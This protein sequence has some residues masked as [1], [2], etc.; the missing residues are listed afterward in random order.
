MVGGSGDVEVLGH[1]ASVQHGGIGRFTADP[2][3]GRWA[4]SGPLY[5]MFGST[6]D[7]VTPDWEFV[8]NHVPETGRAMV[9]EA[10][11]LACD[12][13]GPFTWSH[14][15]VDDAGRVHSVMV[16]G[17]T[18][19]VP[20]EGSDTKEGGDGVCRCLRGYV[21]DL[22]GL[23]VGAA[24]AAAGA[25]VIRSVAPRATIEQAK[26]ALMLAYRLTPEAAFDMLSWHSQHG[27]RKLHVVAA[28]LIAALQS[29]TSAAA[30]CG[31]RSTRS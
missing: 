29:T 27:N 26:G 10:Y 11:R 4:W 18:T 22:T 24:R 3:S 6:V 28:D 20:A 12:Q 5:A 9:E 2:A 16:V 14:R 8:L 30:G 1:F 19:I 7:A 13:V 31:P 23:R 17:E 15:I 25:A 21:I